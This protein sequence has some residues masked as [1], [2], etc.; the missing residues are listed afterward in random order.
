MS[1]EGFEPTISASKRQQSH[2]FDRAAI[3]TD[4]K[5]Y[6]EVELQFH[7]FLTS[8]RELRG[9]PHIPAFS[10]HRDKVSGN[11]CGQQ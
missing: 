4:R 5:A 9:K 3:V 1:P 2:V 6:R 10:T 8:G 11:Q 7:L